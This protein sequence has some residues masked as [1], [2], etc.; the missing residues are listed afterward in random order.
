MSFNM[1]F[2]MPRL[3]KINKNEIEENKTEKIETTNADL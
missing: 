3:L 2:K 1:K